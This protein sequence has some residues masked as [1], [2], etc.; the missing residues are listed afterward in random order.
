MARQN[1]RRKFG[2]L[3]GCMLGILILVIAFACSVF[4]RVRNLS[5]HEEVSE[6]LTAMEA[7]TLIAARV[8]ETGERAPTRTAAPTV[9]SETS[10]P[11]ATALPTRT[12]H[13]LSTPRQVAAPT[14]K[15]TEAPGP[16]TG[17]TPVALATATA[18]VTAAATGTAEPRDITSELLAEMN[19]LLADYDF[20]QQ[21]VEVVS[22]EIDDGVLRIWLRR[23][24]DP[25][26]EDYFGQL[27]L[28]HRV[29]A[30]NRPDVD[31]LA[32]VDVEYLNGFLIDMS[33]LMAFWNGQF[34][35]E[36]FRSRWVYFES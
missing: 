29:V 32:T 2:R 22:V 14:V 19:E 27:G 5:E 28:I 7:A 34:D 24:G 31:A 3:D 35:F 12:L 23:E 25:W 18:T 8:T 1:R 33:D 20:V 4:S 30:L 26:F 10:E 11:T 16:G 36:E 13:P 6:G 9:A 15:P 21:R 17:G